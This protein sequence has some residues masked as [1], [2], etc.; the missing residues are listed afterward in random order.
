[1]LY[2]LCYAVYVYVYD[3]KFRQCKVLQSFLNNIEYNRE[4]ENKTTWELMWDWFFGNRNE[5]EI[6]LNS[7][8]CTL[9]KKMHSFLYSQLCLD[10]DTN[11]I[12]TKPQ[13]YIL[14]NFKVPKTSLKNFET[15]APR[16]VDQF[17][18]SL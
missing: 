9:G 2:T 10:V 5:D 12:I 6:N 1:M 16:T 17:T 8:A 11:S 3:M 4:L 7:T 13:T 18:E 15:V 14:A